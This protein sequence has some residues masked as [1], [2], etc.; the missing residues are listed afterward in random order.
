MFVWECFQTIE[1]FTK[2]PYVTSLSAVENESVE[3]PSIRICPSSW[4]NYTALMEQNVTAQQ[5][6]MLM[7]GFVDPYLMDNNIMETNKLHFETEYNR[8]IQDRP[9]FDLRRFFR[10]QISLKCAEIFKY[11]SWQSEFYDCCD[12]EGDPLNVRKPLTNAGQCYLIY[13][14]RY[15]PSDENFRQTMP[16]PGGGL[17]I[18]M[19]LPSDAAEVPDLAVR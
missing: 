1:D 5:L 8:L 13:K 6:E 15:S 16:G 12:G 2:Q 11:C 19:A 4:I 9:G 18:Q 10:D 17:I 7:E 14:R 3:L